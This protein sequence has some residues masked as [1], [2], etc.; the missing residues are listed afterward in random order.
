LSYYSCPYKATKSFVRESWPDRR[1]GLTRAPA[2]LDCCDLNADVWWSTKVVSYQRELTVQCTCT[3]ASSKASP[4]RLDGTTNPFSA[5][6]TLQ[7]MPRRPFPPTILDKTPIRQCC[8]SGF[9]GSVC[10]WASWI[11]SH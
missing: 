8:G 6:I 1:H 2:W 5:S 7:I 3:V 4:V 11:R 9:V 10:F